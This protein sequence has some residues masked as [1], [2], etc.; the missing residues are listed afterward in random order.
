MSSDPEPSDR[1]RRF[2]EAVARGLSVQEAARSA[3]FAASYARK[4]SRLLKQPSIARAVATIREQARTVAVYG[5]VEAMKEAESA[6]TFAMQGSEHFYS[7][8]R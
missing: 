8:L 1:Q 3:G 6:A 2:I 5:L 4:A 7:R